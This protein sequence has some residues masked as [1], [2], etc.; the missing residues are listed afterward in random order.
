MSSSASDERLRLALHQLLVNS[1][2]R[3]LANQAMLVRELFSDF[4]FERKFIHAVEMLQITMH[5]LVMAL[6]GDGIRNIH[7]CKP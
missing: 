7:S 6:L 4:R 1:D 3:K 5:V 2:L